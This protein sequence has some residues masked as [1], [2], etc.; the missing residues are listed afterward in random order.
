MTPL[1]RHSAPAMGRLPRYKHEIAA[2]R[3][4]SCERLHVSLEEYNGLDLVNL[5]VKRDS[6]GKHRI[7]GMKQTARYVSIQ[8]RQLPDLI[9]ALQDAQAKA[10]TEGLLEASVESASKRKGLETT[11]VAGEP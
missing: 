5:A 6:T 3:K 2:L 11:W 8:L 4:N 9:R 1:R 7:G 10:I